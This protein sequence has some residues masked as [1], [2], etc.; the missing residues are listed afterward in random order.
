MFYPPLPRKSMLKGDRNRQGLNIDFRGA[1][2]KRLIILRKNVLLLGKRN[3]FEG[4]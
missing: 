4:V 2:V 3:F 1:G